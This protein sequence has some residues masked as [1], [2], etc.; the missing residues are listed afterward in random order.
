MRQTLEEMKWPHPN[1]PLQKDNSSAAGVVNNIIVPRKLKTTDRRLY[2]IRCREAQGQ[3]RYYFASGKLK[4]GDY[5]SK[6]HLPLYHES[7]RVQ[8]AGNLDSIKD[9]MSQ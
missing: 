2:C 8:H 9:I 1:S 5:S 4:W 3:F 7:K 6:H